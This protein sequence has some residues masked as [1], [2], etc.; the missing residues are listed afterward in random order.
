MDGAAKKIKHYLIK[1]DI[2]GWWWNGERWTVAFCAAF[3]YTK[4]TLPL[5]IRDMALK[6]IDQDDVELWEY[7]N[8]SRKAS[9]IKR[10]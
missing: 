1:H 10:D 5:F 3:A 7:T 2:Y 6:K 4:N 9:V 8:A